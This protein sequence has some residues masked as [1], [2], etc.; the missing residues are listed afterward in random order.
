MS[1]V[2]LVGESLPSSN[3]KKHLFLQFIVELA[4]FSSPQV[5]LPSSLPQADSKKLKP[6]QNVSGARPG[7]QRG[8]QEP[9]RALRPSCSRAT[10]Y[11]ATR[12]SLKT[13]P[14][15]PSLSLLLLGSSFCKHNA[16]RAG[17]GPPD[18]SVRPAG[19]RRRRRPPRPGLAP[20]A[21]P[22]AAR[23]LRRRR[24]H[25]PAGGA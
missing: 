11:P 19:S 16:A 20:C 23:P 2:A 24:T 13:S 4:A 10:H 22:V 6:R 5:V 12:A 1:G 14:G 25:C 18:T 9:A 17:W 7:R 8:A 3:E 15:R 21:R